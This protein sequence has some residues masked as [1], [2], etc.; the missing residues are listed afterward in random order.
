MKP[1]IQ[2]LIPYIANM[3]TNKLQENLSDDCNYMGLSKT[4]FIANLADVFDHFRFE[5]KD[6]LLIPS[7]GMCCE[8]D[9]SNFGGFGVCFKGNKSQKYLSLIFDTD[10]DTDEVTAIFDCQNFQ[11]TTGEKL[12]ESLEIDNS[13]DEQHKS[14]TPDLDYYI[15]VQKTKAAYN[16]L[17]KDKIN[18][19]FIEDIQLWVDK[20]RPIIMEIAENYIDHHAFDKFLL[21]FLPVSDV[22]EALTVSADFTAIKKEFD[23]CIYDNRSRLHTWYKK[24]SKL[25]GVISKFNK[26]YDYRVI[27]KGYLQISDK[28]IIRVSF[29]GMED[30]VEFLQNFTKAYKLLKY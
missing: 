11:L 30:R 10:K 9:C 17:C 7:N 12:T 26:F 5:C 29:V 16:E 24:Y 14:F 23:T 15:L 4:H 8:K 19:Y 3:D 6:T 27:S 18:F 28:P 13:D 25:Y 2:Q 1:N 20:H 21:L 22:V